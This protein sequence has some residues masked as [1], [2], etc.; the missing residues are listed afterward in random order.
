MIE[1]VAISLAILSLEV[2]LIYD[3]LLLW[4]KWQEYRR[5]KKHWDSYQ[6]YMDK[7]RKERANH[8]S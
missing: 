8:E 2:L 3:A 5:A 6:K 7:K 1:T 4:I